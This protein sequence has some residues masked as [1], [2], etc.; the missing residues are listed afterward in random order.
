[1]Y[2]IQQKCAHCGGVNDMAYGTGQGDM[3][4]THG[5]SMISDSQFGYNSHYGGY[6]GSVHTGLQHGCSVC[7]RNPHDYV[8]G[9]GWVTEDYWKH[10]K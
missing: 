7:G 10:N 4:Y 9:V 8:K 2:Q 5:H 6:N 1:M 3:H